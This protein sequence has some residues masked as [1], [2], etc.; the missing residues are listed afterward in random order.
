LNQGDP[1]EAEQQEEEAE[2]ELRQARS[3]LQ[4]EE[5]QYQ[6]LRAEEQLFR[7]AEETA[8]LLESHRA[9]MTALR[10]VDQER[11]G[12]EEPSRAQKLRLRRI[13]REEASLGTRAQELAAAIEAEGTKVAAGLLA[14]VAS[15]L[16]R[17]AR[18]VSEEGDY[19]TGERVQGLQRDVEEEL[20][21]L[22]DAL[23]AEQSRRSSQNK[24]GQPSPQDQGRPPLIPDSSELKLLRRMELDLQQA[25]DQLRLLHPELGEG[26]DADPSLLED[27]ARLAARH[28]RLT[29]L[30]RDLRARVGIE[31][32]E[33]AQD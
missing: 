16:A 31:P 6:R 2:R 18:D 24:P 26:T 10:E 5:E 11:A 13:G 20:L 28:E 23:R 3:E 15:D 4:D 30:F 8:T 14:N 9:Q 7:I 1:S 25:V 21:W 27:V 12:A 17:I 33:S 29:E 19:Q 32:P 22:I